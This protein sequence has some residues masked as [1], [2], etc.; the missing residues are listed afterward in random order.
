MTNKLEHLENEVVRLTK[1]NKALMNRVESRL[2][3]NKTAFATLEGKILLE[4]SVRD[5]TQ[6]LEETTKDLLDEKNKL[7]K[8]VKALPGDVLMFD[9][10]MSVKDVFRGE[11]LGLLSPSNGE[12]SAAQFETEFSI[13]LNSEVKKLSPDQESISFEFQCTGSEQYNYCGVSLANED[14]YLLYSQDMTEIELQRKQIRDQEIQLIEASKLC[15]LGEMAGGVAHEINTPLCAI[16]LAA[17]QLETSAKSNQTASSEKDLRNIALI[18]RTVERVSK[19]VK[20][21]RQVSRDGGTDEFETCTLEDVITDASGLCTERFKSHGVNLDIQVQNHDILI[22]AKRVQ[23]SQVLLNLLNNSF[24][25]AKDCEKGWIKI[26]FQESDSN[27]RLRVIDCG[28]GIEDEVL[29]EIFKPFF[30]TKEI[31]EGTGLGMSISQ[32][33]VNKHGSELRYELFEGHTSFY[34]DISKETHDLPQ[35]A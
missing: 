5:R 12:S 23:L 28:R 15:S 7:S 26:R 11:F 3:D 22:S 8:L 27:V 19:I 9:G 18:M 24:H 21:L 1:V 10:S 14:H 30:T 20:S 25:V 16:L 6:Q 17:S 2:A 4:K 33:I 34:F 31:G 32:Q 35:I 13:K 29:D